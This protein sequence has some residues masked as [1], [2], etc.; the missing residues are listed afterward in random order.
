MFLCPTE[1]TRGTTSK[2]VEDAKYT[3]LICPVVYCFLQILALEIH[4]S[5]VTKRILEALGGYAVEPR[6]E[7][8]LKVIP[9][10]YLTTLLSQ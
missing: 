1:V 3:V 8:F 6:G 10:S 4:I 7:I 9:V 5:E 2:R